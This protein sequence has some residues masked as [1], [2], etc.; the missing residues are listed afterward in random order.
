MPGAVIVTG[1]VWVIVTLPY[2]P[3]QDFNETV[4]QAFMTKLAAVD[5]LPDA[6]CI[7][8]KPIPNASATLIISGLM[9]LL[10]P[11][12]ASRVF[13]VMYIAAAAAIA[14]QIARRKQTPGH[15]SATAVV[16]FALVYVGSAFWN[17][18]VNYLVGLLLLGVY[19]C[20]SNERQA[21]PVWIM[22]FTVIAFFCHALVFV[23]L[24][25]L[26]TLHLLARRRFLALVL[27]M[28]PGAVLVLLYERLPGYVERY[29]DPP[30]ALGKMVLYKVYTVFKA[31]P[32]HNFVFAVG[33]D[34]VTARWY[35]YLGVSA[36]LAF[37]ATLVVALGLG[38]Y[39]ALKQSGITVHTMAFIALIGIFF[40]LPNMAMSVVNPGERFWFPALLIGLATLPIAPRLVA[41]LAIASALVTVNLPHLPAR[42]FTAQV[43]GDA[44]QDQLSMLFSYRPTA[45]AN[46]AI[47]MDQATQ[48]GQ[49]PTQPIDFQTGLFFRAD[50]VVGCDRK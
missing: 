24:C 5:K 16:I 3:F 49:T 29:N 42:H 15:W 23:P 37:G 6:V 32:Y 31:G 47:A 44:M 41:G 35:Y 17:G 22:P 9:F 43:N 26:A 19:L 34:N 7:E 4:Y 36:N 20:L 10:S 25:G 2:P 38:L 50:S 8:Q 30:F 13:L 33:G 14:I 46:K 40:A 18:Y 48:S 12:Q 39:T 1:L 27:S 21:S 45:F 28:T 11:L